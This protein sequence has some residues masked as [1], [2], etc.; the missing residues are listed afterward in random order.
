MPQRIVFWTAGHC[1]RDEV[2][3]VVVLLLSRELSVPTE[4]VREVLKQ[5]WETIQRLELLLV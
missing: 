2:L 1:N 5:D 3:R 4:H